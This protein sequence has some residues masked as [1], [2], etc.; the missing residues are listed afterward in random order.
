MRYWI[1]VLCL[2][3]VGCGSNQQAL[4]T[5]VEIPTETDTLTPSITPSPTV[6]SSPT[7]TPTATPPFEFNREDL[8]FIP[9]NFLAFNMIGNSSPSNGVALV[10][11]GQLKNENDRNDCIGAG[12]IRLIIDDVEYEPRGDLMGA[13]RGTLDEP[14]DYIGNLFGHC[15]IANSEEPTFV[16][17]DIP[18]VLNNVSF[19][20][21]D[22]IQELG[23]SLAPV[24]RSQAESFSV[25]TIFNLSTQEGTSVAINQTAQLHASETA[26]VWTSTPTST[27]TFTP[28][29]PPTATVTLTQPPVPTEPLVTTVYYITQGDVRVRPEPNTSNDPVTFFNFGDEVQV[30]QQVDGQ[31][32]SGSIVWYEILHNGQQ[33]YVHS[34]LVSRTRPVP[35]VPPA[36]ISSSS[37]SSNSSGGASCSCSGPDL[38]CGDFT[39]R[40]NAQ[41]CHDMCISTVGND[42][43]GLDGN[44]NDGL[45]CE[46]YPY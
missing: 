16:V 30:I 42:V 36:P 11:E 2:F 37:N 38:N 10:I 33:V 3:C 12:A 39:S 19:Q 35:T 27:I 14:I 21:G 18:L 5:L 6:T 31:N 23:I 44:D 1:L 46:T 9:E 29:M 8:S 41:E 26:S 22:D 7:I 43:H 34:S 32:V 4:P 24:L 20:F 45:A 40:A 13:Y 28:T 15:V 17:F 25:D